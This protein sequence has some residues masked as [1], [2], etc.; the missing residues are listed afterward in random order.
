M[1]IYTQLQRLSD[2]EKAE[3]YSMYIMLHTISTCLHADTELTHFD[4]TQN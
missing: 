1:K 2:G 4:F 3:E